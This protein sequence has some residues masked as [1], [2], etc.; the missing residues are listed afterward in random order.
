MGE[1]GGGTDPLRVIY[2]RDT[3]QSVL[4]LCSGRGKDPTGYGGSD[5]ETRNPV[6]LK[7]LRGFEESK[8]SRRFTQSFFLV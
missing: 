6:L 3:R 1:R 4:Q 5:K 8:S 2:G 7:I